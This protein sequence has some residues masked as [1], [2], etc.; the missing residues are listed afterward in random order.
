MV[1]E[2][3]DAAGK[4]GAIKR[5]VAGLDPRHVR[6]QSYAAPTEREKR[7]YFLWRF[8]PNLPGWGGMAVF[9]R[10][11]YGRVLVERVE[12]FATKAEWRRAYGEIVSFEKG[13]AD[14]G[15]T[16]VKLWMHISFKEQLARFERRRDDPL[17]QWK[18]TDEDWRNREKR[19]AYEKA[20]EEMLARTDRPDFPWELV[21]AESKHYAAR[22]SARGGDRQGRAGHAP[23]GYRTTTAGR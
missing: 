11:W 15:T 14:E 13:L 2:G 12:G 6:V 21:P 8:V 19:P 4:G 22:E 23:L 10:S 5:L 17:R 1:F 18:L 16:L 9:D 7:H 3:W 20:V